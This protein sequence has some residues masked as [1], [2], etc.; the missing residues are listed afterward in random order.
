MDRKR[1]RCISR[2][3]GRRRLA[4]LCVSRWTRRRSDRGGG[5][6]R[7]KREPSCGL[8]P[9]AN[10]RQTILESNGVAE[11]NIRNAAIGTV[12]VLLLVVAAW[13]FGFL[14]GADPEVA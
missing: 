6:R 5:V 11:M 9:T 3:T 4:E 1:L 10:V 2:F 13:A 14:G 12:I 7:L 8:P